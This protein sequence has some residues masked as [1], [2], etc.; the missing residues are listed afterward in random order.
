M[1]DN[2]LWIYQKKASSENV[3]LYLKEPFKQ[4]RLWKISL[5]S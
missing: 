2:K 5:A 4:A 1:I 3:D